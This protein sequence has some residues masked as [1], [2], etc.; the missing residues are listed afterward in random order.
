MT[1]TI[2]HLSLQ[3]KIT[4][5]YLGILAGIII[6]AKVIS[7]IVE[8]ERVTYP[9]FVIF[10]FFIA[11]VLSFH[12][13]KDVKPTSEKM[14]SR[15]GKTILLLLCLTA[16]YSFLVPEMQGFSRTVRSYLAVWPFWLLIETIQAVVELFW[17]AFGYGVPGISNRPLVAGSVAEFWGRRWNRLFGDWLVHVCFR[18]LSRNPYGALFFTFLVSALIHEL[19]VSVPLWLV[20][21]VNCFGWMLCYFVIQAIAVV[22]ERKWLRKNP[23]LNRCFT[24]LAVVGPVPLILNR[25]T[26][27]IFHLSSS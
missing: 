4:L 7:L 24:W 2:I 26:L 8:R 21:R 3:W 19:L 22:V 6:T 18:P 17:L 12:S 16:V 27:L 5:Y 23:F 1:D 9:G 14:R 15:A 10:L 20:Y 13:M 25:G 11:P